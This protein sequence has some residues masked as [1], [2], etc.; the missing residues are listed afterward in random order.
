MCRNNLILEGINRIFSI[1]LQDKT[2]EEIGNECLSVALKMTGSRIG[3][4]NLLGDDG[5]LHDIAIREMG[6]KP[7]VMH[8]KTGHRRPPENFV[9]DGFTV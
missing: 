9:V 1:A 3:F 8:D 2:E 6:W 5:L 7:C 4:V